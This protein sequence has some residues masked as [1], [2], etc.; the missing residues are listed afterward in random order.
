M[1]T[2]QKHMRIEISLAI[3]SAALFLLTL[4]SDE[5]IEEIFGFEPDAGS[6]LLEWA[7]TIGLAGASALLSLMAIGNARRIRDARSGSPRTD[8]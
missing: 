2:P 8:S 1:S 6:G 3:I 5:W 7:L 4:V